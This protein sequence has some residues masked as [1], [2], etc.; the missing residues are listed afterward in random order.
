MAGQNNKPKLD[1]PEP[2]YT[3]DEPS[4]VRADL[5]SLGIDEV[6]RGVCED[7]FE[8]RR[9]LR[10]A[11]LN[12]EPVYSNSGT[13]SG[14]IKV[15]SA[16][17]RTE[18]RLTSLAEK[19]P[20]LED[21]SNK[22]SDYLTGLHLIA[23]ESKDWLVPPWVVAATRKYLKEQKEGGPAS[24][25]RQPAPMPHRCRIIKDDGIRCMLW[26]SGRPQDNGMCRIHLRSESKKS[27]DDIERARERLQQAAPHAVDQL[28]NLM[29]SAESEPVKLK[30]ATEILDRAGIRGGV[31]LDANVTVEQRPAAEIIAERLER[32]QGGALSQAQSSLDNGADVVDAEIVEEETSTESQEDESTVDSD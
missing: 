21:R 14:L 15:A 22:N 28:E 17:A 26:G 23:E 30:A 18:R 19:E 12:W 5:S 7:T 24:E 13:L 1:A 2:D 9:V 3:L 31:E 16:Q 4:N 6:E 20:I 29:D 25:K 27:S 32:L 8:N 10:K 11:K